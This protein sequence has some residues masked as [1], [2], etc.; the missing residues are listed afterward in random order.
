MRKET[1]RIAMLL[2]STQVLIYLS[3][4]L[5][6]IMGGSSNGFGEL[7]IWLMWVICWPI[8]WLFSLLPLYL[9]GGGGYGSMFFGFLGI[10]LIGIV[11]YTALFTWLIVVV[12]TRTKN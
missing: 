9:K 11:I 8:F 3:F 6:L 5:A 10:P 12:K 1:R 7:Y 4:L 2:G